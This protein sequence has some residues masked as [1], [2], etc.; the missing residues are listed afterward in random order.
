[1]NS[2]I[3]LFNKSLKFVNGD[4]VMRVDAVPS[5]RLSLIIIPDSYINELKNTD[6]T[7]L[8][9]STNG[10]TT[11]WTLDPIMTNNYT[12]V[13]EI[14]NPIRY[15]RSTIIFDN[16]AGEFIIIPSLNLLDYVVMSG[17][18]KLNSCYTISNYKREVDEVIV[19]KGFDIDNGKLIPFP[20]L[21][22]NINFETY[23]LYLSG[24]FNIPDDNAIEPQYGNISLK[25]AVTKCVIF[26]KLGKVDDIFTDHEDRIFTVKTLAQTHPDLF[27][28][29][30]NIRC[31]GKDLKGYNLYITLG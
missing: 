28:V 27:G 29:F 15:S 23:A 11:N 17:K 13:G 6:I 20:K 30:E 4:R 12:I 2:D 5:K 7:N 10:N 3:N 25:R 24:I 26:H 8:A 18:V 16:V 1:M 9:T 19:S 21:K 14:H 31:T 22:G